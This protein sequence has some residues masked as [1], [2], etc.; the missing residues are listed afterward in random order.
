[1]AN[2]V[3]TAQ[4]GNSWTVNEL[5]AY[6]ITIVSQDAAT[7]F[8]VEELTVPEHLSDLLTNLTAEEAV[9]DDTYQVL[10]YMDLAM[11]PIPGEESAVV[12]FSM[13]LL[14]KLGYAGRK[15]G[16]DL[17]SRKDISLLTCG[18]WWHTRTD[19][20]VM[21]NYEI[22]L[23]VQEDKRHI[24]LAD[25]HSQLIAEAI[26]A[27]Q[28]NNR[29]RNLLG[30]KEPLE[31]KEMAGIVMIGSAPTFFKIPVSRDLLDA[32]QRGSFPATPTVVAM[33]RPVIKRPL[34][35]L[36]EG[37]RPLDNRKAILGCF[38]AFKKFVNW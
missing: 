5:D 21:D 18:E 4:T 3:R 14:W 24:K 12:D 37:M 33:H 26:A 31:F 6:N 38:E 8:G 34:R 9:E 22:L 19:L 13:Q 23:I 11:N 25:P 32:V 15:V 30:F 2:V 28:H 36:A 16:R 35:R 29:V 20:C 7:F 17:R 10:R 1:M 27:V